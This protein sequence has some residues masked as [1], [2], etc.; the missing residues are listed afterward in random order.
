MVRGSKYWSAKNCGPCIFFK[1]REA[2]DKQKHLIACREGRSELQLEAAGPSQVK[3]LSPGYMEQ[4]PSRGHEAI[5]ATENNSCL[6]SSITISS[7]PALGLSPYY[8]R[9]S[10]RPSL[11]NFGS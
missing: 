10:A 1:Q 8:L 2:T 4:A 3:N 6:F 5:G 11:A 7:D 9:P